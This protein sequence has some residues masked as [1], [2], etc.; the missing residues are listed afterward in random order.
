[1]VQYLDDYSFKRWLLSA[2]RPSLKKEV[3]CRGITA[4]FSSIQEILEKSKDIEDSSQ[5]DIRSRILQEEPVLHQSADKSAPRA[6]KQMPISNHNSIR[7]M[8]RSAKSANGSKPP[9]QT[10]PLA[11]ILMCLIQQVLTHLSRKVN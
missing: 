1:M 5:Y 2:L 8:N 3:L 9:L 11:S 10:K 7:F 4:E 6:F